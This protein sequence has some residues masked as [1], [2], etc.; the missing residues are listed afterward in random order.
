VSDRRT[1]GLMRESPLPPGRYWVDMVK[2]ADEDQPALFDEWALANSGLVRVITTE[3]E[4]SDPP[5]TWYLFE[6]F[7][8]PDGFGGQLRP[9][10]VGLGFP[11]IAGADVQSQDDTTTAQDAIEAAAKPPLWALGLVL[12]GAALLLWQLRGLFG[13][14][15]K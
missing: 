14:Q 3:E 4:P 1:R 6:T 9:E 5:I 8:K 7:E 12:G 2:R 15:S 10:W 13:G 11:N